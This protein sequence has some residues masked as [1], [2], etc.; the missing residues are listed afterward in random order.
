MKGSSIMS[1]VNARSRNKSSRVA[2]R[3]AKLNEVDRLNEASKY[4]LLVVYMA[5]E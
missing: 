1:V 4:V 3:L 5:E 2:S